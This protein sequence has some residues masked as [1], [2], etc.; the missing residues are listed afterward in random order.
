MWAAVASSSR[1]VDILT[2]FGPLSPPQMVAWW[3]PVV[4]IK[5]LKFGTYN[6]A[7]ARRL[8]MSIRVRCTGKTSHPLKYFNPR[9]YCYY[10]YP[11]YAL[12]QI[13]S[14]QFHPDGTCVAAGSADGTINIW[15]IRMKKLLQHYEVPIY[16]FPL[17]KLYAS[18][19]LLCFQL[20]S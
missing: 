13:F 9:M 8:F 19:P 16:S 17:R 20:S 11:R 4:M 14:V 15:D 12:T 2:G 7:A 10:H 3:F 1:S 5:P 6:R 18:S